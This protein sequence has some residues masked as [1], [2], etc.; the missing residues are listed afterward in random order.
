MK[1]R[2]ESWSFVE[3]LGL[4]ESGLRCGRSEY[5]GFL[6]ERKG[7]DVKWIEVRVQEGRKRSQ[8]MEVGLVTKTG[9]LKGN[10]R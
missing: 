6:I 7:E 2:R 4:E 1:S 8:N 10:E 9:E 3:P 5:V